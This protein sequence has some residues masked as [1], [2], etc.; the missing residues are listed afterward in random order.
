MAEKG[1]L[2]MVGQQRTQIYILIG[3]CSS[4]IFSTSANGISGIRMNPGMAR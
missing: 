3:F 1:F 4:S 2:K